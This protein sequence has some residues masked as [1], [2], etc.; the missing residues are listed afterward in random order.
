MTTRTTFIA[1]GDPF[2]GPI[3]PKVGHYETIIKITSS[4]TIGEGDGGGT[5][6]PKI[7]EKYFSG[8]YY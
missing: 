6:S 2:L 1:I 4:H 3:K 7:W 8:N 5:C